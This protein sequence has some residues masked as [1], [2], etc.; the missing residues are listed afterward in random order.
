MEFSLLG[1]VNTLAQVSLQLLVGHVADVQIIQSVLALACQ[2]T[3]EHGAGQQDHGVDDGGGHIVLLAQLAH[4]EAA[5]GHILGDV[6]VLQI[7][8]TVA[9]EVL[10]IFGVG[11]SEVGTQKKSS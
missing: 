8:G 3:L 11:H 2:I 9:P 1:R 7:E 4:Q 6:A 10:I 5:H